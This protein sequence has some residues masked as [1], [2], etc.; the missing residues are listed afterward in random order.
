MSVSTPP[1]TPPSTRRGLPVIVAVGLLLAL[2]GA[3][4]LL[5][6]GVAHRLFSV[7]AWIACSGGVLSLFAAGL[8]RPGTGR[9]GF[10]LSLV[11]VLVGLGGFVLTRFV[12]R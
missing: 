1:F 4:L 8:T 12:L 6:A 7:G 11:G 2:L 3:L 10:A 9:R 5:F